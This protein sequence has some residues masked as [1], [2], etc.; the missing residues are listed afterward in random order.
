MA[1]ATILASA[2]HQPLDLALGEIASLDCQVYDG[3]CAFLGSRFH[4]AKPCLR[5]ND[6]LA[7][8]G[9]SDTASLSL[10]EGTVVVTTVQAT[11]PNG[12][13]LTYSIAGGADADLFTIANGAL[14]FINAP[15]Y[16][17]PADVGPD[18]VYEVTVQASDSNGGSDTQA[19]SVTITNVVGVS[20]PPS[21]AATINGTD[22]EDNLVGLTGTN[23][24]Q[25]FGGND[26]LASGSGDDVLDGG[27]GNDRLA[28]ENG[29]DQLYGG[30]GNDTLDGEKGDGLLDGGRGNDN[31]SGGLG[32]DIYQ[33]GLVAGTDRIMDYKVGNDH[34]RLIEGLTLASPSGVVSDVNGDSV[35]DTTLTLVDGAGGVQGTVQILGVSNVS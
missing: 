29:N 4:A 1:V 28:G 12:D 25:G 31:L 23:N 10:K 35:L 24:L 3:W 19:L 27:D 17:N 9:G 14:S 7:S 13:A 21:N 5:G 33:F 34:I 18:N 2:V 32:N 26:T 30:S 22:E 8:N 6:C 15:D 16:E 11:E 20:P